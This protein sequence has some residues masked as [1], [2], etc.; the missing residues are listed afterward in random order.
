MTNEERSILFGKLR[1]VYEIIYERFAFQEF[2]TYPL[3]LL[4]QHSIYTKGDMGKYIQ[5]LNLQMHPFGVYREQNMEALAPYENELT[6][7]ISQFGCD[8]DSF[9]ELRPLDGMY[10][11]A[12]RTRL[13]KG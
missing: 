2:K 7:L 6:S 8:P 13:L 9:L 10:I 3:E 12:Y 4:I 1:A 11:L 5:K